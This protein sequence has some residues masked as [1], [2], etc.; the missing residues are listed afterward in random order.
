MNRNIYIDLFEVYGGLSLG[1]RNAGWRCDSAIKK[2][3]DASSF[4]QI[5]SN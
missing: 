2:S 5:L 4:Y 3:S 1:L